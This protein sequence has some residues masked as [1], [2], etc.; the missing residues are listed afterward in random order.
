MTPYEI[1]KNYVA[2]KLHFTTNY[3]YVKYKG[4]VKTVSVD[5]YNA[6]KDRFFFE[7]LAK[8]YRSEDIIPFLISNL[9][10]NPKIWVGKLFDESCND[11]FMNWQKKI[12]S[13]KKT[14]SD[15]CKEIAKHLEDNNFCVDDLFACSE[16]HPMLYSL[17]KRNIICLETLIILDSIFGFMKQWEKHYN[18][19]IWKTDSEIIKKYKSFFRIEDC[20]VYKNIF[21]G[22]LKKLE[23]FR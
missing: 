5:S 13:M 3:D 10:V 9:M 18:D 14:F 16:H 12:Q 15:D 20:A 4:S 7:K 2:I 23:V 6:R 1:Y 8:K 19:P 22:E 11:I 17:Y 21:V